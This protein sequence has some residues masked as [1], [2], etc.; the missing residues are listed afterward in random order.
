VLALELLLQEGDLAILAVSGAPDPGLERGGTVL[1]E[2]LLPAVEH[3]GTDTVFV[4]EIGDRCAFQEVKTQNCDLLLRRETLPDS[5][6]HGQT[7]AR[8]ST[9]FERAVCPISTE[10]AQAEHQWQREKQVEQEIVRLE[11]QAARAEQQY[12]SVD[13]EN[14]LIAAS[15]EKKWESALVELEQARARL[16]EIQETQPKTL[17]IPSELRES[18]ADVGRRMPMLWPKLTP[19]AKKSLLR[20]LVDHVNLLRDADGIAQIRIVWRGGMVTET[21]VRV[22]VN[23]LRYT[24]AEKRVVERMRQLTVEGKST[25]QIAASLNGEGLVPC[26]GGSFTR[27]IVLKFKKRFAIVSNIE[28]VRRGDIPF[29]YTPTE[30]A[31]MLQIDRTWIYHRITDGS[32]RIKKDPAYDCYLFPRSRHCMA[33]F[34]RLRKGAVSH[35]SF[36]E[37]HSS[38]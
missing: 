8:N 11:Y 28:K 6:R 7:S 36:P 14:R 13:P 1:Q 32:I 31:E 27:Q 15:L 34:R 37:G 33:Q 9:L 20:T 25:D 2:L 19:E 38:G 29:A 18:F 16:R 24:D 17:C 22:P 3:R 10:A 30:L 12:N 35:V 4:T 21:R 23:S 5:L 26:R